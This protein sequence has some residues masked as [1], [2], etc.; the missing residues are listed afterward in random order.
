M[1]RR[2][3]T[4]VPGFHAFIVRTVGD[5]FRPA[6]FC[7]AWFARPLGASSFA[8]FW[9][10]WNPVYGYVL[11]Y[12]VYRP[13]RRAVPRA[14]ATVTTFLVSG[15]VLHDI[16]FGNGVE[17]LRGQAA[18]PE[19][20]VLMGI[21]GVMTAGSRALGLDLSRRGVAA[22]VAVN[23]SLLLTGFVLRRVLLATLAR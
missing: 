11:L 15:F 9:R 4:S 8:G 22:R 19:V 2:R 3:R 6:H 12:Y 23:A 18:V 1:G 20:T 10:H 16:P 21:F 17:I 13:L 7:W 14:A 5:P